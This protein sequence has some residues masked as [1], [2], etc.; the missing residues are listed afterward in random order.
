M[1]DIFRKFNQNS[2]EYTFYDYRYKQA[3]EKKSGWRIDHILA[4]PKIMPMFKNCYIDLRPRTWD[5]PSDHTPLIAEL[6]I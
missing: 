6:D 5:K 2:D 3:L 4:S 1:V